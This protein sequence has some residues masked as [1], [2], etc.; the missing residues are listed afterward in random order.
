VLRTVLKLRFSRVR[1][2]FWFRE[3]V[4]SWPEILK[5]DS[6]R[7]V[8]CSGELPCLEGRLTRAS[9]STCRRKQ[10]LVAVGQEGI[11]EPVVLTA[12]SKS[13]NLSVTVLISLLK[14]NE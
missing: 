8:V 1:K 2:Y 5:T 3:M 10:A 9:F 6:S 7:D 4:E 14:Q 13:T 12:I 11:Q